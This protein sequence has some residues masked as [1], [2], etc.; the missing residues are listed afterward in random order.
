L[1]NIHRIETNKIK[2]TTK[3]D[4]QHKPYKENPGVNLQTQLFK[5]IKCST[6]DLYYEMRWF[7]RNPENELPY[8]KLQNYIVL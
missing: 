5:Y 4:E 7:K 3:K 2:S 8:V 1:Q 6:I